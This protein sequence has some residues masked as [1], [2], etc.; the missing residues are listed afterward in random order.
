MGRW[1]L[2]VRALS[3]TIKE[4]W[5]VVF[6]AVYKDAVGISICLKHFSRQLVSFSNDFH[7]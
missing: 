6:Y 5:L 4:C 1:E 3:R 2:T 7:L